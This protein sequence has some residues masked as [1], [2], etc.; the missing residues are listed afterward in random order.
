MYNLPDIFY[1]PNCENIFPYMYS[2]NEFNNM[3]QQEKKRF[4][5]AIFPLLKHRWK[6][7]F[8]VKYGNIIKINIEIKNYNHNKK[9]YLNDTK[10]R[11]NDVNLELKEYIINNNYKISFECYSFIKCKLGTD[12]FMLDD[13]VLRGI[14]EGGNKLRIFS[15]LSHI[16]NIDSTID[17]LSNP[18][19]FLRVSLISLSPDIQNKVF[20]SWISK[21]Q[22]ILTGSTGVGKTSQIPKLLLWFNYLFGG[23]KKFTKIT[24]FNE[25]P[26]VLSLPRITLVKLHSKTLLHSLGFKEINNSPISLKFG[27]ITDDLINKN[28]RKYGI[29]YS[30]HKLTL[31][32]IFSYS[33]II[34]DEVHEHDQIGDIIIAV[35]RKYI[36]KFDSLC[37]MTAT[38]EDDRNRL[39]NFLPNPTFIHI[40]SD[41]LFK[42]SEVYIH[43]K[44][45]I[46]HKEQYMDEE[47]KNIVKAIKLYTPSIKSSGIVFVATINQCNIYSKYLKEHLP[48]KIYII[49][50]KI[51]NVEEILS[52]IYSNK[53]IS[54][55]I[56]TPYL[57]SS[58]TI[59]NVTHIYDTGRVYIPAPFG[60]IQTFISKSMRDQRKGRVGRLQPGL[61]IYFY[62]TSLIKSI[63]RIDFE[64]LHNY[65]LYSKY[66]D[67]KIPNDLLVIPK[68]LSILY[69]TKEY[70]ESFNINNKKWFEI[71]SSHYVNII[72][73]AKI[74]SNGG[75]F[76]KELDNFERYN[77]LNSYSL[78][79]IISLNMR[80]KIL[81]KKRINNNY[82][83]ICKVCFG[84]FIGKIF[85]FVYNIPLYGY[86]I[87]ISE[88]N[89][90]PEIFLK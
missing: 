19:P 41:T 65:V 66:F 50:G 36:S 54:I 57:E 77:I 34:V 73:Y 85:T 81:N 62:N 44:I 39:I 61:Y 64:F 15:K 74:Y 48:Y 75:I 7:A 18:Y 83:H 79:A 58:I 42:I 10:I 6:D 29:V 78:E 13:F 45:D 82:F 43:N 33:T 21:K 76:A 27:S 88:N 90:I 55:I 80:I 1:F 68:D 89:F 30:T 87:M 17:I 46:S 16:G 22:I 14:I 56:S 72:E 32:K 20:N 3:S 8:I 71:L 31:S 84:P 60:G 12:I 70:I 59:N 26:I 2:Q 52:E 53:D 49:H 86:L 37:L 63:R 47:K 23:F 24:V 67:L 9:F 5:Y 40:H 69:S 11:I 51:S 35:S 38:L 25:K 28:P 4:V